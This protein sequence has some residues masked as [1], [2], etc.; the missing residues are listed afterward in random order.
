MRKVKDSRAFLRMELS[1]LIIVFWYSNRIQNLTPPIVSLIQS[2]NLRYES[3]PFG[4]S[5]ILSD[6]S[7]S[8]WVSTTSLVL[9]HPLKIF[10]EPRIREPE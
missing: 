10:F 6:F 1:L 9:Q 5:I 2:T 4:V 8:S 3:I 7:S